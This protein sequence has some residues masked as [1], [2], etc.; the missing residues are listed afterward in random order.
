MASKTRKHL[1]PKVVTLTRSQREKI[2]DT[3][4]WKNLSQRGR[5]Y[6][7]AVHEKDSIIDVIRTE[8]QLS[9]GRITPAILR[10]ISYD[11]GVTIHTLNE[12]LFGATRFPRALTTRFVLDAIGI[13]IR[14]IR[15]DGSEIKRN[16][17]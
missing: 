7:F 9:H 8:I 10:Q 15:S 14:Y 6:R 2:A 4:E 17:V 13:T 11:S 1:T 3:A 12:W 5:D 16:N